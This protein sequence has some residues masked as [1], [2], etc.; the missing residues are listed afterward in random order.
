MA[1]TDGH[2]TALVLTYRPELESLRSCVESA[3][4][5]GASAIVGVNND[6][7]ST[8][9]TALR[10]VDG[11]DRT[12]VIQLGKNWGY[13]GGINRLLDHAP[14]DYVLLLNDD[15]QLDSG[16]LDALLNSL[17]GA[18]DD[19]V[20]VT[21]KVVFAT[22]PWQIDTVGAVVTDRAATF[23]RGAFERDLGQYPSLHEVHGICFAAALVRRRAFDQGSVGRLAADFFLYSED[24]DWCLR[25]RLQGHRFM[26]EPRARAHHVH[27]ASSADAGGE[28]AYL[29][30]RN[31]WLTALR[32]FP[33]GRALLVTTARL[34]RH[35]L[36]V[37]CDPGGESARLLLDVARRTPHTLRDRRR[38]RGSIFGSHDRDH[39]LFRLASD[40]TVGEPGT[41]P[42]QA[43]LSWTDARSV[44][45]RRW[46]ATGNHLHGE[47][48]AS[49]PNTGFAIGIRPEV[50]SA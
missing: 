35:V 25:A 2:V 15:A 49:V 34:A 46:M 19:V 18:P 14:G 37:I 8:V 33:P 47:A 12:S 43:P 42:E 10:A 6:D 24:S 29:I 3:V 17:D 38:I 45:G 41:V 50:E 13:A 27:S 4:A 32:T 39:E 26:C 16:A 1:T 30:E 11:I 48:F 23:N 7:P 20:A 5:E 28:K 36:R 22:H 31:S 21:P 9:R 40:A 44:L